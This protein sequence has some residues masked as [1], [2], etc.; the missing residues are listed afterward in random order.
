MVYFAGNIKNNLIKIGKANH[1]KRRIAGWSSGFPYDI[2]LLLTLEGNE[3]LEKSLHY[4]FRKYRL[5]GEWFTASEEILN[6]I[7]APYSIPILFSAHNDNT[8]TYS[9]SLKNRIEELYK[10]GQTN[11]QIS[12]VLNISIHTVRRH[13]KQ[14]GLAK[15]YRVFTGKYKQSPEANNKKNIRRKYANLYK[16]GLITYDELLKI[17]E[18]Y[19]IDSRGRKPSI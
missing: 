2:T 5:K 9:I 8:V 16:R 18:Q 17:R 12:E 14:N 11:I 6:F 13:I 3:E 4:H 19:P 1:V 7:S 15:K 10:Q